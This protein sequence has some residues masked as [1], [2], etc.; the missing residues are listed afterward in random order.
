MIENRKVLGG[1]IG[2]RSEQANNSDLS[3]THKS[4]YNK[5]S[6]ETRKEGT[7]IGKKGGVDDGTKQKKEKVGTETMR[8]EMQ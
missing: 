5:E 4:P 7:G 6:V 2:P 3:E 8:E 1:D